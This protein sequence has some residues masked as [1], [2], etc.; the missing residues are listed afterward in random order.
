MNFHG[1][2]VIEPTDLCCD[3]QKYRAV[4]DTAVI[5]ITVNL[6]KVVKSNVAVITIL[7]VIL[8]TLTIIIMGMTMFM[9]RRN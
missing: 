8:V 4:A 2:A 3:C 1:V 6:E 5:A 7:I 9:L